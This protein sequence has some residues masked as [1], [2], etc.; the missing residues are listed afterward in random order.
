VL[1]KFSD[2][3]P[4]MIAGKHGGGQTL[5]I[6]SF[7]S[8]AYTRTRDRN[9]AEFFQGLL[10]W[11]GVERLAQ[12]SDPLVEVRVLAGRDC[13]L[14]FIFNNGE[15]ETH[16]ELKLQPSFSNFSIRDVVTEQPV[17]FQL[18]G[19]RVTLHRTLAPQAVW[20]LANGLLGHF[21]RLTETADEL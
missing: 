1:A 10:D 17:Q 2:G 9:L 18:A 16:A 20:V 11:A 5:M 8:L 21:E 15:Q 6:G 14:Y 7:L 3:T 19:A 12:V 13:R 4:A